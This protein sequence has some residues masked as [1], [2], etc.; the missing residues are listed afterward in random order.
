VQYLRERLMPQPLDLVPGR[1]VYITRG[2]A[3]HSRIV[4]NEDEVVAA[5]AAEFGFVPVDPAALS[6]A[7]QIRAFAEAETI[8]APHGAALGNL[9][10]AHPEATVVELFPPDYVQGCYWKISTCVGMNYRYLVGSGRVL[11]HRESLGVA[12]DIDL[13]LA[14]LIQM[15]DSVVA[16]A[17]RR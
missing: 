3:R 14:S 2:R 11:K 9:A 1:R 16:R 13:E 15:V 10:F 7:D 17:D 8:V 5:L 4:R 6:V 12:S